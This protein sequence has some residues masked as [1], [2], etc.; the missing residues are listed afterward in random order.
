MAG[1]TGV[2]I[3]DMLCR[4]VELN[5]DT[6][7]VR[8]PDLRVFLLMTPELYSGFCKNVDKLFDERDPLASCSKAG[9]NQ[10]FGGIGKLCLNCESQFTEN[11]YVQSGT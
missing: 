5:Q 7:S 9:S 2:G 6:D 8:W 10:D 3:N 1:Q 4:L 11:H